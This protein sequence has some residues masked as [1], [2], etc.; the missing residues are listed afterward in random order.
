MIEAGQG[1]WLVTI[2]EDELEARLTV[3]FAS[4][5]DAFRTIE[6]ALADPEAH[7]CRFE[8]Y[9]RKVDVKNR[10]RTSKHTSNGKSS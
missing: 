8:S 10:P 9:K 1:E 7:W 6:K 2:R 5:K 4:L 3:P